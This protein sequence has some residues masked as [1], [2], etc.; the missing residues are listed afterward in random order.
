MKRKL[1][2]FHA[3]LLNPLLNLI[4]CFWMDIFHDNMTYA[5]NTL[6]HPFYVML[7]A[8]SGAFGCYFYSN[9]IWKSPFFSHQAVIHALL[10]TGMI[11][12]AMIPYSL[13]LPTWIN[14]LH[15]WLGMVSVG[16]FMAEWF[17]YFVLYGLH[18]RWDK[19][20]LFVLGLVIVL[21]FLP[22]SITAA[23]Q[24]TFS[25]LVNLLLVIQIKTAAIKKPV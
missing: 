11:I 17:Y 13:L 21:A 12:T 6:H 18:T 19:C 16:G 8:V 1:I 5:S 15:V 7:W 23:A 3:F 20:F 25:V 14:D 4:P 22:G 2:F 10:C 9:K 24:I